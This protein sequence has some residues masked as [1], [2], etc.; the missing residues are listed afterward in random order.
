MLYVWTME[1]IV[2]VHKSAAIVLSGFIG[3]GIVR[4]FVESHARGEKLANEMYSR[5][6]ETLEDWAKKL[7]I[8]DAN[9]QDL[10]QRHRTY[11]DK[12][13]AD[14]DDLHQR[15]RQLATALK[16]V[17]ELTSDLEHAKVS[18]VN[19]SGNDGRKRR[20]EGKLDKVLERAEAL[21]KEIGQ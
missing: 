14:A 1:I 3:V 4:Y 21:K 7:K 11:Q 13:E 16:R 2:Y 10:Y 19:G 20:N 12:L 9:L 5:R 8:R 15:K 18:L 17:A 6:K